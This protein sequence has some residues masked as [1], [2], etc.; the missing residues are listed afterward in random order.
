M[1]WGIYTGIVFVFSI[2]VL[3]LYQYGAVFAV[4]SSIWAIHGLFL[5]LDLWENQHTSGV[6]E[7][8][9]AFMLYVIK[10]LIYLFI[11]LAVSLFDTSTVSLNEYVVISIIFFEAFWDR[12]GSFE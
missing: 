5:F 10:T 4:A 6:G 2:L 12:I 1:G 3:A 7:A 9:S 11:V 8:S